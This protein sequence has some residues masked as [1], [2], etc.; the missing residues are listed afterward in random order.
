MKKLLL[1]LLC[2]PL[3]GFGQKYKELKGNYGESISGI[4]GWN[5]QGDLFAFRNIIT[6]DVWTNDII[7]IVSLINNKTVDYIH[8]NEMGMWSE[9]EKVVSSFLSKYKI[10]QVET[11]KIL[12]V[13]DIEHNTCLEQILTKINKHNKFVLDLLSI[14]PENT[15]E[16]ISHLGEEDYLNEQFYSYFEFSSYFEGQGFG[17]ISFRI[18]GYYNIADFNNKLLIQIEAKRRVIDCGTCEEYQY[19]YSYSYYCCNNI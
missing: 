5:E 19:E 6:E 3:I 9:Q 10:R 4:I 14:S 18:V 1:I 11:P 13:K 16:H 17:D 15:G 2:L 12:N 8:L 7:T